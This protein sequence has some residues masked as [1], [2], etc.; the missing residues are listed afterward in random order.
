[1]TETNQAQNL[2]TTLRD[3]L[4]HSKA[5]SGAR[6]MVSTT[7][8]ARQNASGRVSKRWASSGS[9]RPRRSGSTCSLTP[10]WIYSRPSS[11]RIGDPRRAGGGGHAGGGDGG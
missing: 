5:P 9:V 11:T 6:G 7:S 1:M 2:L 4:H 8:P 3:A 10:P